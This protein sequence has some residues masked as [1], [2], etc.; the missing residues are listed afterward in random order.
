MYELWAINDFGT[1]IDPISTNIVTSIDLIS[2]TKQFMVLSD[3]V[4]D[5][6]I[7][8]FRIIV[9]YENSRANKHSK[10]F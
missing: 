8:D 5:V 9:F 2:A 1:E 4:S 7:H 6:G 10:D 3:S